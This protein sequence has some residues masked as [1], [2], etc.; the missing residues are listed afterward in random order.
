MQE[1]LIIENNSLSWEPVG[2]QQK[3]P[4]FYDLCDPSSASLVR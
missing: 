4:R 3:L 2:I 1:D